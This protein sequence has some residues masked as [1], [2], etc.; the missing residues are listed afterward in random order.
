MFIGRHVGVNKMKN[1]L[2]SDEIKLSAI[3]EDDI[4]IILE[5]FDDYEFLTYFDM[6]PAIPQARDQVNET[7]SYFI[8]PDN[9]VIFAI[10]HKASS[11]IIGITGLDDIQW[12]NGAATLFIGIGDKEHKGKGFGKEAL[13]MLINFGFYEL[14]LHKIQLSVIAYNKIAIGLYEG[15][16]FVK[17]GAYREFVNRGGE[18]ADLCLYGL[19]KSEWEFK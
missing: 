19:L 13:K 7:L 8:K 11:R 9:R 2:A 14:N 10:R 6:L 3:R 18:R 1:L 4:N 5:W 17:E 15:L 12:N 16:G